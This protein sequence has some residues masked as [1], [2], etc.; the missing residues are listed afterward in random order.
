[1]PFLAEKKKSLDY[2]TRLDVVEISRVPD[3]LPSLFLLGLT[4][5]QHPGKGVRLCVE[6]NYSNYIAGQVQ[7]F[8]SLP[9]RLERFRNLQF[10]YLIGKM[11]T[12]VDRK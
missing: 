2:S 6:Q 1:M 5:S 3:I 11:V 9:K 10:P 4:T 7:S 8:I 12:F